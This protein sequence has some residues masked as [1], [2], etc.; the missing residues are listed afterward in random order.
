MIVA[1]RTFRSLAPAAVLAATVLAVAIAHAGPGPAHGR[2]IAYDLATG[3]I[4]F[5]T[6]APTA[7]V[8][9]HAIGSGVVV[10]TGGDNCNVTQRESAF[11]ISLPGGSVRWSRTL[12]GSC[13]DYDAASSVS[14]GSVAVS[15]RGGAAGWRIDDGSSRWIQRRLNVPTGTAT[16]VVTTNRSGDAVVL[17]GASGRVRSTTPLPRN[18][19]LMYANGHEAVFGA[20]D[21]DRE[22]GISLSDGRVL[23]HRTVENGRYWTSRGRR[24]SRHGRSPRARRAHGCDALDAS[25]NARR[26]R[27]GTRADRR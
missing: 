13:F 17:D 23:W 12:R 3:A 20:G 14:G 16:A 15:T 8:H 2:L 6:E 11:A 22:I 24:R 5:D 26:D 27:L 9:L 25:G 4:R 10:A 7:S 21:A 19:I 18:S 1:M